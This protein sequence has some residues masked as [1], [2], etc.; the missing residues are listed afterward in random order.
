MNITIR[1]RRA[2]RRVLLSI[3]LVAGGVSAVTPSATAGGTATRGIDC[4]GYGAGAASGTPGEAGTRSQAGGRG[5]PKRLKSD[6]LGPITPSSRM[7]INNNRRAVEESYADRRL[8]SKRKRCPCKWRPNHFT[9]GCFSMCCCTADLTRKSTAI[10][11]GSSSN[12]YFTLSFWLRR[13]G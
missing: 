9:K 8:V 7:K 5:S 12:F 11:R 4:N 1:F 2:S 6:N 10:D 13:L 3:V